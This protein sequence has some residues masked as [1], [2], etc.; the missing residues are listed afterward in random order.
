MYIRKADKNDIE[1]WMEL[2]E[3]V[4]A[5]FPGLET[6]EALL[7]HKN[8]VLDFMEK[9]LALC[10]EEKG[11]IS[12]I[13]LFSAERGEICFLAV[14]KEERR[15]GVGKKLLYAALDKIP[16]DRNVSLITYCEGDY[17]GIAAR[18]FYKKLGFEEGDVTEEFGSPAQEFILK[19]KNREAEIHIRGYSPSDCL[20]LAELFQDTVHKINAGDYTDEQIEAWAGKQPDMEEWNRS[21]L[22]HFTAVAEKR[23]RIVGFGDMDKN[24]YLDRF[25]VDSEHQGEG[26]GSAICDFLENSVNAV[27]YSV[28]ASVTAKG[29]FEKRGYFAVRENE[30]ERCGVR[31]KN[32]YMTRKNK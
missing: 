10:A 31:L 21:F 6:D 13:L 20:R 30:A 22:D 18:A 1:N 8:T 7:E 26:I 23:G 4:K 25:Y 32:Y 2:V 24:G 9:G 17:N 14:D 3:K 19:S 11:K 27:E 12:G 29:F 5:V 15:K 16:K 28:Y